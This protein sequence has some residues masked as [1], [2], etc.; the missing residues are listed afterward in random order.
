MFF[1]PFVSTAASVATKG[2]CSKI[3]QN[4]GGKLSFVSLSLSIYVL[5]CCRCF[6]LLGDTDDFMGEA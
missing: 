1:D 5:F 2:N 4:T 3:W 6:Y